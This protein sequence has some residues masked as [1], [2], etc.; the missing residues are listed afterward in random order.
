M[1]SENTL[2]TKLNKLAKCQLEGLNEINQRLMLQ[3]INVEKQ[4][5]KQ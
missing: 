5:I 3:K 1:N 4:G 2:D